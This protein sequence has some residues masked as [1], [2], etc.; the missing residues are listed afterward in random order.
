MLFYFI[1]FAKQMLKHMK[2]LA[3]RARAALACSRRDLT[4][5]MTATGHTV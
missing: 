4:D 1:F 2:D 3:G 5:A